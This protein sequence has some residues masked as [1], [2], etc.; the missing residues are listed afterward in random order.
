MGP[1][2]TRGNELHF[3]RVCLAASLAVSLAGCSTGMPSLPS[4]KNPFAKAEEKLP[5]QRV[6]VIT[7]QSLE[8]VN[9]ARGGEAGRFA[10]GRGQCSL[11]RPRRRS[12]E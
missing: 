1:I 7:D 2:R 9:P 6:A 3:W 10:S 5:G 4:I 8:A 11:V 12:I